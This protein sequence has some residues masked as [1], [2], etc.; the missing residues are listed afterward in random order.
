[1]SN[2][3]FYRNENNA[4][5]QVGLN[6]FFKDYS[7]DEKVMIVVPH[8]D[9]L[10]IGAGMMLMACSQKNIPIVAVITTDGSM[11]YCT[12]DQKSDIIQ[13][14][15]NE[16]EA[17]IT[18]LGLKNF[19]IEWCNYPDCDLPNHKGRRESLNQGKEA[20]AGYTGLQNTYT[21]LLRKHN[22][23]RVFV[24][25]GEDY[26]PDHKTVYEELLIS[27]FHSGGDIWPELGE[28]L[29]VLPHLYEMAIYCDFPEKPNLLLKATQSE[30]QKKLESIYAYQSQRQIK[31][32][33]DSIEKNGPYELFRE[34]SFKL[35][36]PKEYLSQFDIK[37]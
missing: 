22:P 24:S 33:V 5:I 12:A 17:S 16:T 29:K 19:T 21:A 25:T 11:G 2:F 3:S 7:V 34:I 20:N 1:M 23:T 4:T 37:D 35:Y 32:V 14:R 6:E 30:F 10:T 28:P 31:T 26:H 36:Q 27:I 9:D 8:D 18:S 15:K 13:I